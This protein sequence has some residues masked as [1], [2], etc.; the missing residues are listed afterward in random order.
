MFDGMC[1][2]LLFV[3][4]V[5]VWIVMVEYDLLSDEGVVYVDKLCVVGNVVMLVCYL[6]MIYE[7]FKMGGY[8]LEVWVVYVDVVVVLKVV[9][10]EV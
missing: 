7:F 4:V 3:G 8:V 2:V 1:D 9:F 6:G 5:L 10:D